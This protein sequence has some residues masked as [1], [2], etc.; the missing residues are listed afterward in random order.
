[1]LSVY[2]DEVVEPVNSWDC[3]PVENLSGF[4]SFNAVCEIYKGCLFFNLKPKQKDCT[5]GNM[6]DES[7]EKL[8]SF[9]K[10][11][12]D[13]VQNVLK[14]PLTGLTPVPQKAYRR[15]RLKKGLDK[16]LKKLKIERQHQIQQYEV[17]EMY[18]LSMLNSASICFGDNAELYGIIN[19]TDHQDAAN[20]LTESQGKE[21][22]IPPTDRFLDSYIPRIGSPRENKQLSNNNYGSL[23]NFHNYQSP[24][25]FEMSACSIWDGNISPPQHT[26]NNNY[27]GT[28]DMYEN[29]AVQIP[30]MGF[31]NNGPAP[32]QNGQSELP[33]AGLVSPPFDEY[34]QQSFE[35]YCSSQDNFD[36]G[37]LNTSGSEAE[38]IKEMN[39]INDLVD[40]ED[41]SADAFDDILSEMETT[42][43]HSFS[44][45]S[46]LSGFESDISSD[47]V[48]ALDGWSAGSS[49]GSDS[50]L[51]IPNVVTSSQSEINNSLP[52]FS[53]VF[54][55]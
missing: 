27:S 26:I 17:Q 23:S 52:S 42:V 37:C 36:N 31:E 43:S 1:M 3:L 34:S 5:I 28:I 55:Q 14:T 24:C 16:T 21:F 48:T 54:M 51:S 18:T 35:Q 50:G 40:E 15:R 8:I 4:L 38:S 10:A 22:Y 39:I 11:A 41:F 13:S 46:I 29:P 6:E 44:N 53:S 12:T 30:Y 32:M 7:P 49:N 19:G 20:V 47:R 25:M 45:D 2:F 33:V 9:V